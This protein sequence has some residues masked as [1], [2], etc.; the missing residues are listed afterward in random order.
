MDPRLIFLPRL[1]SFCSL[2]SQS[3]TQETWAG[4]EN[5]SFGNQEALIKILCL[6]LSSC[7]TMGNFLNFSESQL[8]HI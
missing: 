2:T 6:T 8:A 5:R 4:G 1:A 7:V 3:F